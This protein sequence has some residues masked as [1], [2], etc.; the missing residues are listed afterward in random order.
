MPIAT[1]N[2]YRS[3]T[4]SAVNM[5]L[6]SNASVMRITYEVL[7]NFQSFMD[8]DHNS[9]K[10][11]SKACR[12]NIYR[13]ISDAPNG[14]AAENDV[15]GTNISKISIPQLV[16]AANAVKYYTAIG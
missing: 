3:C 8:F 10:S 2:Q 7:T 11:L 5:K 6:S 13:I 15:L 12:K 1:N 14:I 4:K 16:V 9:I